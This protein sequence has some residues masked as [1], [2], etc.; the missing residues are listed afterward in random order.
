MNESKE[1]P[2]HES[3]FIDFIYDLDEINQEFISLILDTLEFYDN[4]KL[5]IF[6]CNRYHL[7]LRLGR[8]LLSISS[9]YSYQVTEESNFSMRALYNAQ[10]RSQIFDKSFL[11]SSVL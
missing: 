5:C 4:Y 2:H 10:A 3:E 9:K 11:S 1:D 8:Y 6:V 7:P